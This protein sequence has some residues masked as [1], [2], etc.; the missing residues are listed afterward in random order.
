MAPGDTENYYPTR[1][2]FDEWLGIPYSND[3]DWEVD[4]ITLNNIFS[5][6]QDIPAKWSKVVPQ[7]RRQIYNPNINDWQVPLIASQRQSDGTF[8]DIELERP[9]NQ[10]LITQRYTNESVRFMDESIEANKPFSSSSL[11]ACLMY[12]FL[13]LRDLQAKVRREYMA[14]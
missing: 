5:P 3:M 8:H 14:M 9:A 7:I 12:H 13:P 6:S 11:T 4:G 1:H 2:G 10:T